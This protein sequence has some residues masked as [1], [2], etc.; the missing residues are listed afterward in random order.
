MINE[1]LNRHW[2]LT[3]L[4]VILLQIHSGKTLFECFKWLKFSRRIFLT[5]NTQGIS[6]LEKGRKKRNTLITSITTKYTFLCFLLD[7]LPFLLPVYICFLVPFFVLYSWLR[8]C[9]STPA[10]SL[11]FSICSSFLSVPSASFPSFL[12]ISL[13]Q[14]R[15]ILVSLSFLLAPWIFCARIR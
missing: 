6:T 2:R 7:T 10:V 4:W 15:F 5:K 1:I 9:S 14:S 13:P 8:L 11:R 3:L 12:F